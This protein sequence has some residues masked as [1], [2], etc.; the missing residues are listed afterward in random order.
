MTCVIAL[1]FVMEWFYNCITMVFGW[2]EDGLKN[3]MMVGFGDF[4]VV[5]NGYNSC[6]KEWCFG[7]TDHF[8]G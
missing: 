8:G 4:A 5:R 6:Y 2:G 1:V 7:A 3:L